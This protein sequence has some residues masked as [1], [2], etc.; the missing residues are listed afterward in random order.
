MRKTIV[1]SFLALA[2]SVY[3][4]IEPKYGLS[5][6][7]NISSFSGSD[8]PGG[9]SSKTGFQ[10]GGFLWNY[11]SDKISIDAELYYAQMGAKFELTVPKIDDTKLTLRGK[12]KN[13]YIRFPILFDYHPTEEFSVAVGPEI[14]VLLKNQVKYNQSINGSTKSN[15]K[16][17]QQ[18]DAGLKAKV[19]YIFAEHYLASVGY[20]WGMT[21]IYKYTQVNRQIQ[22]PPKIYNSNLGISLGYVF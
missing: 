2:T 9:F 5:A 18:F 8:K 4:Q 13:D 7:L 15:P 1:I 6:G 11:L 22:E 21:K 17:V 20:Y 14:G 3:A 12:I 10:M 19:Q 16:N